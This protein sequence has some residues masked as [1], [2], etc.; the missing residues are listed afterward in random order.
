MKIDYR[1]LKNIIDPASITK[2]ILSSSDSLSKLSL[3]KEAYVVSTPKVSSNSQSVSDASKKLMQKKLE[4]FSEE[5]NFVSAKLDSAVRD[6]A[7]P[8]ASAFSALKAQEAKLLQSSFLLG[9][10]VTNTGDLKSNLTMDTLAYIRL[11]RDWGTFDNWQ[12]DF[13][14]CAIVSQKFVITAYSLDLKRYINVPIDDCHVMPPS[15]V[16]VI[17]IAVHDWAFTS[18]YGDDKRS[19]V[20][21]TM[22]ELNWEKIASRF[23]R[24]EAVMQAYEGR[25]EHEQ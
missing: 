5:L 7:M 14:A 21:S 12:K 6:V 15:V 20:F 2:E 17:V 13:V 24:A 10:H 19:Y 22:R 9:L 25:A 11:E 18:D 1:E 8:D 16:P 4:L 3:A 23:N